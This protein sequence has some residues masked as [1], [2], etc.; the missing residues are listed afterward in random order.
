M[1]AMIASLLKKFGIIVR[2][3]E[4]ERRAGDRARITYIFLCFRTG[5]PRSEE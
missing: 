4:A 5:E 3:V 1:V 2:V